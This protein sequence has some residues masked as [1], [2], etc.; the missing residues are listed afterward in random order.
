[1]L[2]DG[3]PPT[4]AAWLGVSLDQTVKLWDSDT[5]HCL[6]T[7]EGHT[8]L[9][10]APWPLAPRGHTWPA[11][12]TTKTVVLWDWRTGEQIRTLAGHGDFYLRRGL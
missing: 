12:A 8:E 3:A 6:R 1:M 10:A 4:V 11:A 5:G 2:G 9:G 7:W